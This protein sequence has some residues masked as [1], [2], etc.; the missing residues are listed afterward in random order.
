MKTVFLL[1]ALGASSFLETVQFQ[2]CV[3]S[4]LETYIDELSFVP[5]ARGRNVVQVGISVFSKLL[6]LRF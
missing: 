5:G 3:P 1:V 6:F 4:Q 2:C